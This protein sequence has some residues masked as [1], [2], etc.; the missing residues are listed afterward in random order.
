MLASII[1]EC[2]RISYRCCVPRGILIAECGLP[3]SY[4]GVRPDHNT[5]VIIEHITFIAYFPI[6]ERVIILEMV[7]QVLRGSTR[8]QHEH[9][10]TQLLRRRHRARR[11]QAGPVSLGPA[12]G[13]AGPVGLNFEYSRPGLN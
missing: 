8:A 1:A 5:S 4:F 7:P 6:Y 3:A 11:P 12:L 9:H 10:H 2:V 13:P